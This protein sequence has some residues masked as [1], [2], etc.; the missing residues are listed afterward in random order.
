MLKLYAGYKITRYKA[1]INQFRLFKSI[2]SGLL[3]R[4]ESIGIQLMHSTNN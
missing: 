1:L 4:D 2:K 3:A